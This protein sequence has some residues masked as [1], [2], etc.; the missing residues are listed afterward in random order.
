MEEKQVKIILHDDG[1]VEVEASGFIGSQCEDATAFIDKIFSR[2]ITRIRK[3]EYF[4]T[5]KIADGIPGD[6]CG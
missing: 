3:P 5:T 2:P 6:Y 4:E 1:S